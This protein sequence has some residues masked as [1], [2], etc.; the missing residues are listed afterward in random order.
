MGRCEKSFNPEIDAFLRGYFSEAR[1]ADAGNLE[2]RVGAF[3]ALSCLEALYYV[4]AVLRVQD[5]RTEE[6]YLRC[7]QHCCLPGNFS[8]IEESNKRSQSAAAT[9]EFS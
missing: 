1:C 7:A 6:L 9:A 4:A 3:I 5:P 8:E 2:A